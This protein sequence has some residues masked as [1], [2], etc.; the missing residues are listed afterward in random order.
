MT[1]RED[2]SPNFTNQLFEAADQTQR[3]NPADNQGPAGFVGNHV[4]LSVPAEVEKGGVINLTFE[5]LP[6]VEKTH[7]IGLYKGGQSE[8]DYWT[9]QWVSAHKPG[10][11]QF[12]APKEC[13]NVFFRYFAAKTYLTCGISS[14]VHIGP[15]FALTTTM[16]GKSDL[17]VQVQYLTEGKFPN[18]WL[19]L[20]DHREKHPGSYITFE[21]IKQN[22]EVFEQDFKIPKAGSYTIRCFPEKSL[23]FAAE[24][25]IT[26]DGTD[27]LNFSIKETGELEVVYSLT[28][29]NPKTDKVWI[30][31]YKAEEEPKSKNY[32]RYRHVSD[33]EG[34]IT[35]KALDNCGNFEARL[36]SCGT[37]DVLCRSKALT[38]QPKKTEVK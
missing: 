30:G 21:Y 28:T 25:V 20:Y 12:T 23:D 27:T 38:I 26:V 10:V 37:Y 15:R 7:W 6:N 31:I 22:G 36:F 5:P 34:S 9:Y 2:H 16:K 11:V 1:L 4:L 14:V 17:N 32:I 18:L 19:G 29:V 24:T 13:C 35:F 3:P 33:V 8:T